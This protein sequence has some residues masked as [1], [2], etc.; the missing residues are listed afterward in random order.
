MQLNIH[1]KL[2]VSSL[3]LYGDKCKCIDFRNV[4]N[5]QVHL[6]FLAVGIL[7]DKAR[8]KGLVNV[9]ISQQ[10]VALS[11]IGRFQCNSDR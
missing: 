11:K 7:E 9:Y 8:E 1:W 2:G 6:L 3:I 4:I 10:S 5:F